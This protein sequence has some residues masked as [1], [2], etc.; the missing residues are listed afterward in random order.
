MESYGG[1]MTGIE[2]LSDEEYREL[3]EP[4]SHRFPGREPSDSCYVGLTVHGVRKVCRCQP[5]RD[6]HAKATRERQQAQRDGLWTDGRR[7]IRNRGFLADLVEVAERHHEVQSL[8]RRHGHVPPVI[9]GQVVESHHGNP[10]QHEPDPE[11]LLITDA[12][13]SQVREQP[14]DPE[15]AN[16]AAVPAAGALSEDVDP[17]V[18]PGDSE[19]AE[20][21]GVADESAN[22]PIATAEVNAEAEEPQQA[23]A[24]PLSPYAAALLSA[25]RGL[26]S[27]GISVPEPM[28]RSRRTE[29][30]L[31][32]DTFETALTELENAG[33]IRRKGPLIDLGTADPGSQRPGRAAESSFWQRRTFVDPATG[34]FRLRS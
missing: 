19:A 17:S 8:L 11:S 33:K 6:A 12:K 21:Q 5:C 20:D 28:L 9:Q 34:Q 24:V 15:A 13:L 18:H 26:A 3:P 4:R 31:T 30:G 1:R 27:N 25:I 32:A 2:E 16:G 23:A 29:L 14:V 22:Q 10:R 7:A